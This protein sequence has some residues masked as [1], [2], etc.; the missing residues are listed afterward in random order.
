MPVI[1]RRQRL[2]GE[3]GKRRGLEP[4]DP[5]DRILGAPF[6]VAAKLP[7]RRTW[8]AGRVTKSRHGVLEG[9]RAV[10][11]RE[12]MLPELRAAITAGVDEPLVVLIGHLGPVDP[13]IRQRHRARHADRVAAAGHERHA[14]RGCSGRPQSNRV[15]RVV[16]D[17]DLHGIVTGERQPRAIH[18]EWKP[19][20]ANRR[21]ADRLPRP[22]DIDVVLQ[23]DFGAFGRARETAWTP[24]L[25]FPLDII[26]RISLDRA[27]Q[28]N[29]ADAVR[30]LGQA[31]DLRDLLPRPLPAP[32]LHDQPTADGRCGEQKE[33][34][35]D[36]RRSGASACRAGGSGC[37]AP[38]PAR[39]SMTARREISRQDPS[40]DNAPRLIAARPAHPRERPSA[41]A[42]GRGGSR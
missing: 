30:G 3:F 26:G 5:A 27:R 20:V 4:A 35:R 8:T 34:N 11:C 18:R 14:R 41:A 12:R 17:A 2:A 24:P 13:V 28:A 37:P 6:R 25:P 29:R 22:A 40:P 15:Q 33:C 21:P 1:D 39:S 32:S 31:L 9:H 7:D 10:R 36:R 42:A 16:A 38:L 23:L 19:I